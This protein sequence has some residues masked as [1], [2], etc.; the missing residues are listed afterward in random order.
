MSRKD[1]KKQDDQRRDQTLLRLLKTPPSPHVG[2]KTSKKSKAV[3]GQ[4]QAKKTG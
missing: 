3:K 4:S 2:T 1:D